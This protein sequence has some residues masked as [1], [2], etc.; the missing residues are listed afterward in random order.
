MNTLAS[1]SRPAKSGDE[2][3]LPFLAALLCA[4]AL[5]LAF[6][7]F[8]F[9]RVSVLILVGLPLIGLMLFSFDM[10]VLVFVASLFTTQDFF[11]FKLAVPMAIPLV[12]A[13]AATHADVRPWDFRTGAT[14]PLI[15]YLM[16][17]LPS[18]VNS[19][20]P[21]L[22]LAYMLNYIM[23]GAA[24]LVLAA[25]LKTF[26]EIARPLRFFATLTVVNALIVIALGVSS[27]TRVFG[28]PGI[29]YVDFAPIVILTL[30]TYFIF[31][32]GWKRIAAAGLMI[33]VLVS[34]VMGQTRNTLITLGVATAIFSGY[35]V[36]NHRLT[37]HSRRTMVV[38]IVILV[39]TCGAAIG[40]AW[41]AAPGAFARLAHIG[42]Q[43]DYEINQTTDFALNSLMTRILIWM[44]AWQAFLAHPVA[45]VGAFS[46]PF[47]S[48][49]YSTLPPDLFLLYVKGV[50]P[51]ITYLA[52]LA[53]TGILGFAGF[54]F[55]LVK[56]LGIAVQSMRISVLPG[57]RTLSACLL[58]AQLYVSLSMF[59][60]D[61]WLW[62]QCGMLWAVLLGS[63]LAN[64]RMLQLRYA[65]PAN[66]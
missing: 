17:M 31:T 61:A 12:L 16:T 24:V 44:T 53:E 3:P 43:T 23:F 64:R 54:L 50:G 30:L 14:G 66:A 51:H 41:V 10:M 55:L 7:E 36:K 19:P 60:T 33:L 58:A 34:L 21:G 56:S 15:L 40:F 42:Q 26:N 52:L 6:G 5:L 38:S 35:L 18:L 8:H 39:V 4:A 62:G 46:F 32:P 59:A 11:L 13:F 37:G 49:L 45:G 47:A 63:S 22:T 20:D 48:R 2:L 57:E 65:A 1:D 29:V 25:S 27:G 9:S 28:L